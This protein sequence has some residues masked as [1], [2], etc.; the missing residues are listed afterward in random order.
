MQPTFRIDHREFDRTLQKYRELSKRSV[1]VI[2]N[3]KAFYI[4]RRAVIETPRA[5]ISEIKRFVSADG[6][7]IM[8]KIINKR[9]GERGEKGLYGAEMTTAIGLVLAARLRSR[10][11]LASGW[12]PA[13]KALE[14]LAERIGGAV[15]RKDRTAKEFGQAK[16]YGKP[17]S[18][19]WTVRAIFANLAAARWDRGG[20]ARLGMTALQKAFDFEV[21]S[22]KDYIQRKLNKAAYQAGVKTVT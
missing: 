17:A 16:G 10:A 12:L 13:V 11:F 9:R 19:G 14:P 15:P 21:K 1:Q 18:S 7:A 4:A 22:M 6:G 20:Q 8:G 2:V 3:T 5:K